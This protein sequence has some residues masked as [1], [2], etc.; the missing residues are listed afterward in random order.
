MKVFVAGATGVIGRAFVPMLIEAGH[1][2]A[3]MSRSEE[4]CE[5]LRKLGV[6]AHVCDVF[7]EARLEAVLGETRPDAVIN[8]LTS[9]PE[10]MNPRHIARE[11]APTN[12]L[13]SQGTR[14]LLRAAKATGVK[15]FISQSIAFAYE[16]GGGAPASEDT[17]LYINAPK[18]YSSVIAA[19][20]ECEDA[21][22]HTEGIAGVVLRYG[23]LYGPGTIYA[24]DGSFARAVA[25]RGVPIVGRGTGVLSYVHVDDAATATL[26]ALESDVTGVFNIVDDEPVPVSEWLP[27]FAELLGAKPPY[28]APAFIA[29]LIGGPYL[30]YMTVE[31]TGASNAHAKE[32][33]DWQ[34]KY[35]SWREGFMAELK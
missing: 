25:K 10:E 13:R 31:Q 18:A 26:K 2:V 5:R 28:R 33:L 24:R 9:I 1:E 7:D 6:T 27:V 23:Y 20:H 22:L 34:P 19:V 15:R 8:Q 14:A 12:K 35:A 30:I 21:T 4:G 11:M 16:P 32:A 29:R 17:R 3:A